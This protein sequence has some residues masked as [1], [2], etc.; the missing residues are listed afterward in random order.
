M[1]RKKIAPQETL[2][3]FS[4]EPQKTLSELYSVL[5]AWRDGEPLTIGPR[6]IHRYMIAVWNAT[7]I[8][9]W[10]DDGKED[11]TATRSVSE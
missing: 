3:E 5:Q 7:A 8:V 10:Y 11:R 6:E 2:K 4:Y 9:G 1:P